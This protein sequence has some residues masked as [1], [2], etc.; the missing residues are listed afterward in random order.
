[1][2]QLIT[3]QVVG[4]AIDDFTYENMN[5]TFKLLVGGMYSSIL[6]NET[7]INDSPITY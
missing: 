1:M 6:D 2:Y 7:R 4:D 5:K 3:L